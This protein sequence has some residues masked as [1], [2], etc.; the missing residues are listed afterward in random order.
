MSL[1]HSIYIYIY[2]PLSLN[3]NVSYFIT[4]PEPIFEFLYWGRET[5]ILLVNLILTKLEA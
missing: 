1:S 5:Q 4:Q 3:P 2:I